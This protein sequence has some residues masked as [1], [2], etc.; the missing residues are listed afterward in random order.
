MVFHYVKPNEEEGQQEL[1]ESGKESLMSQRRTSVDS[2]GYGCTEEIKYS[3]QREQHAW[4]PGNLSGNRRG[5]KVDA[6][7]R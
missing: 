7:G 3:R 1:E 4:R 5:H 6:R 2:V